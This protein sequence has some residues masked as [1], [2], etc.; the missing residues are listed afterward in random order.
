[1]LAKR[2]VTGD[3][4]VVLAAVAATTTTTH[5]CSYWRATAVRRHDA[6]PLLLAGG[7]WLKKYSCLVAVGVLLLEQ[8][9]QPLAARC[10]RRARTFSTT[11]FELWGRKRNITANDSDIGVREK[12][13]KKPNRVANWGKKTLVVSVLVV[14]QTVES[15]VSPSSFVPSE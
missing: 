11:N 13:I 3:V 10:L 14:G 8:Q 15:P 2:V 5:S 7:A 1:M 4:A 9:E 12:N 6:L